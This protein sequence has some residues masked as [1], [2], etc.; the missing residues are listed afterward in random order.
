[1]VDVESA[2]R[3][4][5]ADFGVVDAALDSFPIANVVYPAQHPGA[6]AGSDYECEQCE[7]KEEK[8][9]KEEK[10]EIHRKHPGERPEAGAEEACDRQ[11]QKKDPEAY[12]GPFQE[13]L[14]I[15]SAALLRQ[16]YPASQDDE[17]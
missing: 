3:L 14:T 1:M 17:G 11:Q 5:V 12:D 10:Q 4:L 6:T 9:E 7:A 16:P 8:D 2:G 15:R 13:P